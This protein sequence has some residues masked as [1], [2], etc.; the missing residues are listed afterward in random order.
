MSGR[1]RGGAARRAL[2]LGAVAACALS[3]GG[4]PSLGGEYDRG[5]AQASLATDAGLVLGEFPLRANGVVD[6]DTIRVGGLDGSLRLLALDTEETF[7]SER[8]RRD[9]EAGWESYLASRMARTNRPIKVPTPLGEEAKYFA[10][11]FFEG[12]QRVRIERDHPREIRGRFNRFL[13][14]VF[15]ERDGRWVNYN[16]ECVRAGMSPYFTKY[17]YSRRFHDEFV[18]AQREAR[19]AQR[20]IWDPSKQHY[21]DYDVRLAWW[22][23]R[24]DFVQSFERDAEGRADFVALTNWDALRRLDALEGQY[25]TVLATVGDIRQGERGPTRVMLSRRMF[26][27]LPAVFFDPYVL[28]DSRARDFQGEYVRMRGRVQR[29]TNPY[30]GREQLQLRVDQA[31]QVEVPTYTPPGNGD[32]AAADEDGPDEAPPAE[33]GAPTGRATEPPVTTEASQGPPPPTEPLPS[34]PQVTP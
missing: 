34:A 31:S 33:T 1:A 21:T 17:G 13:A 29:W 8:D 4:G 30:N 3:C 22:D 25:V 24:A 2:W 7:K 16:V 11:A 32:G 23:A 18:A 15:V 12:V 9:Y 26:S 10:R 20:G 19:E 27:D 28:E 6:G 14:Y 5:A